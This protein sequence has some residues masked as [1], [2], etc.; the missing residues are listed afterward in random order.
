MAS[1][2]RES[3]EEGEDLAS[4]DE[5]CVSIAFSKCAG[6]VSSSPSISKRFYAFCAEAFPINCPESGLSDDQCLIWG[7]KLHYL[8]NRN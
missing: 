4:E 1:K 6:D 7:T 8:Q 2:L 3:E 5:R